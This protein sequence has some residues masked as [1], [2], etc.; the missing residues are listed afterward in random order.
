M[1]VVVIIAKL[2]ISIGHWTL[3]NKKSPLSSVK[4]I[5]AAHHARHGFSSKSAVRTEIICF[6]SRVT[7][8]KTSPF[9]ECCRERFLTQISILYFILL[10]RKISAC[11][12]VPSNVFAWT[13][14]HYVH[15][16]LGRARTSLLTVFH[17]V[18]LIWCR[19]PL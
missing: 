18:F 10:I 12:K 14:S 7:S 13:S 4:V 3:T 5:A 16:N 17:R 6:K 9:Y 8:F 15:V 11:G 2:K 19:T 1:L